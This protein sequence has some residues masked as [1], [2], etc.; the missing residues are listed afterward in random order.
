MPVGLEIN[1]YDSG[2][3]DVSST[4]DDKEDQKI[5]I[6]TKKKNKKIKSK[7]QKKSILK[8][9]KFIKSKAKKKIKN[10]QSELNADSSINYLQ[11]EK[12]VS[13]GEDEVREFV[14]DAEL[15]EQFKELERLQ[16]DQRIQW[17]ENRMTH[18]PIPEQNKQQAAML[19]SMSKL[20]P[21][22][23]NS[24]TK[25]LNTSSVV[26]TNLSLM[27][28]HRVSQRKYNNIGKMW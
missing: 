15:V 18:V 26:T 7:S 17:M 19:G 20:Y 21:K 14:T 27:G 28:S 10:M 25:N 1:D 23:N 5:P 9:S 6:N 2:D 3:G 24:R 13:F 8:E 12:K 16:R 4:E 22:G 11:E